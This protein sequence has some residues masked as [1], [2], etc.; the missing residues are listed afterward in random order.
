MPTLYFKDNSFL[1]IDLIESPLKS[2][3]LKFLKHLQHVEI[4]FKEW[5]NPYYNKDPVELLLKYATKLGIKINT[6]DIK[7]NQEALNYLHE[8]YEENYDGD[9]LWLK[10]HEQIHRCEF[11]R[12]DLS[13]NLEWREKGGLLNS[14]ISNPIINDYGKTKI[15]FGD[16][17]MEWAELGKT[18]YD[19]WLD[20]EPDDIY[21]LCQLAKPWITLRPRLEVYLEDFDTLEHRVKN[22]DAFNKWW[23]KYEKIWCN[24]W[25]LSEYKFET[26]FKAIKIG[27][28][29]DTERLI[30]NLKKFNNPKKI[31]LR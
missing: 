5:D 16:V 22:Q 31:L 4:D 25:G 12:I 3:V 10:F 14:T 11:K 1:D 13:L 26:Q 29:S 7:E 19:Y 21:R 24:H 17:C 30:D 2:Y 8:I 20:N 9:P 18:P 6:F 27:T 23:N 28:I 15:C